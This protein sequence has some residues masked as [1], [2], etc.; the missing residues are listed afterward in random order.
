[1]GRLG[2][3][4]CGALAGFALGF[5]L[6]ITSATAAGRPELGRVRA[7]GP[8]SFLLVDANPLD[9]IAALRRLS[10]V[11]HQGRVFTVTD[12]AALRQE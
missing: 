6:A 8:A 4:R 10:L 5:A 3:G 11:V 12:L 9:D 1:M 2:L 7:G